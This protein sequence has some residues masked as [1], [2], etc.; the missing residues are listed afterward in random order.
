MSVRI[1]DLAS[2]FVVT[3]L[4]AADRRKALHQFHRAH[5]DVFNVYFQNPFWGKYS[6]LAAAV[7][8]L[9]GVESTI[10]HLA[11]AAPKEL[12]RVGESV[13]ALLGSGNV[14][15]VCVMFV[16]L[17]GANG[18][19]VELDAV[20]T[21]FLALERIV[22]MTAL[23][24]LA[25]HE[26][27]HSFHAGVRSGRWREEDVMEALFSE[28]LAV[29]VSQLASPGRPLDEYLWMRSP[30]TIPA[31]TYQATLGEC[32]QAALYSSREGAYERMFNVD[33]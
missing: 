26:A 11:A 21:F 5:A 33:P 10:R 15:V 31:S 2:E 6:E 25:A 9:P 8:R 4:E 32:V 23:S 16:G 7:N 20:P 27:T 24:V 18:F 12:V 1:V 19:Q 30:Q 28:G 17:F 22:D 13:S 3:V 14:D 29:H